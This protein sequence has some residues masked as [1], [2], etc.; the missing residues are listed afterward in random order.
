MRI[1]R[2]Q[3]A[4]HQH[5]KQHPEQKEQHSEDAHQLDHMGFPTYIA[6][7]SRTVSARWCVG[8]TLNCG[9][10]LSCSLARYSG[11]GSKKL[12]WASRMYNRQRH[13]A[14]ILTATEPPS[15]VGVVS[16]IVNSFVAGS[17]VATAEAPLA[18]TIGAVG[19]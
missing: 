11:R 4:G 15:A 10:W 16:A 14:S 6:K 3:V 7:Q 2:P 18:A 17:N 1:G 13:F 19:A 8:V 9:N 5:A 12:C